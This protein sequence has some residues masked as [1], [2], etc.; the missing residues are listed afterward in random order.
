MVAQ[1]GIPTW[2][3]PS[4]FETAMVACRAGAKAIIFDDGFQDLS[5]RTHIRGLIFDPLLKDCH[6]F[7]AGPLR[8][9]LNKAL[10]RADVL[11]V[12]EK[13]TSYDLPQSKDIIYYK[14]LIDFEPKFKKESPSIAFCG[15]GNPNQFEEI[16]K[17]NK[18][19]IVNFLVF[20]DHY[21]YRADDIEKIL[22]IAKL[23]KLQIL[24]TEKDIVKI[25]KNYASYI[26]VATLRVKF[27]DLK[28]TLTCMLGD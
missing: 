17:E 25:P 5:V 16:L 19:N 23:K 9:P 3:G 21:I 22:K 28:K 18:V 12:E 10:Q 8:E 13:Y 27:V 14:R 15:I 7:P 6:V 4:R 20:P 1:K 2:V 24:T 11:F 26:K